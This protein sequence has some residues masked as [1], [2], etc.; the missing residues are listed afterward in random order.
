MDDPKPSAKKPTPLC[1]FFF[2]FPAR[3]ALERGDRARQGWGS[4]AVS[5]ALVSLEA[6]TVL[7]H[8]LADESCSAAIKVGEDW[9]S[10]LK[11]KYQCR[12]AYDTVVDGH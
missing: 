8:S 4:S 5:K 2:F 3:G 1:V 10:A 6:H 11:Q 12:L 7:A 9:R